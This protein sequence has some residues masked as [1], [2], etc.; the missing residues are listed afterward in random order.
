MTSRE[1]LQSASVELDRLIQ[2][3]VEG[4]STA[5]QPLDT[6]ETLIDRLVPLQQELS[7]ENAPE[8]YALLPQFL[9][10]AKRVQA[11]LQAGTVFHCNSIFGRRETTDT[12]SSD[13]T[14]NASHDSRIIFQG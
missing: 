11:L 3:L 1:V 14:F 10:K 6:V 9:T 8:I 5:V 13:G 4:D 2:Q 12:Y 7:A